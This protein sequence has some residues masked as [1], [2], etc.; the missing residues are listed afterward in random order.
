[1]LGAVKGVHWRTLGRGLIIDD[2]DID[3]IFS[4]YTLLD[5]INDKYETDGARFG[6]VVEKFL[7]SPQPSWR[8][9][10]WALYQAN[11]VDLADRIRSYAEPLEGALEIATPCGGQHGGCTVNFY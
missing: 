11:A 7:S 5:E 6:V 10:I 2:Y 1:M 8:K 9:V 3:E 4:D